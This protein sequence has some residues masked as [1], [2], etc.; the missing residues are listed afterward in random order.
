M[1]TSGNLTV[2]VTGAT[3]AQG[4][5]VANALVQAQMKVRALTREPGGVRAQALARAGV[6]LV[7]GAFDDHDALTNAM[8]GV[9][10]AFSVQLYNPAEPE[11]ERRHAAALVRAARAARVSCFV[12][13][14]VSGADVSAS[15]PWWSDERWDKVYWRNKA[16]IERDVMAAGF[17]R[18]VVLRP[19]FMMENFVPPKA[20]YMFPG[21]EAGVIR[22]AIAPD[23]KIALVA[24]KD[25]GAAAACAIAGDQSFSAL[26][27]AGDVLTMPDIAATLTQALNR[28]IRIEN[29]S[30]ERLIAEGQSSGWVAMQEWLNIA[31]YPARPKEMERASLTPTRFAEWITENSL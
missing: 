11:A 1:G 5:A 18:P 26:E 3:G 20:Q 2:L 8:S 7:P 28:S 16:D 24:A 9:D 6:E 10:A 29:A 22:T 23:A 30:P 4:G 17:S 27:L 14:T 25:I 12:Q 31:G 19:A 21:L 15:A 13:S